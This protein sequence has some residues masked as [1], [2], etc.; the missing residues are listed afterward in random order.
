VQK[1]F[2]LQ[3]VTIYMSSIY[4][5]TRIVSPTLSSSLFYNCICTNRVPIQY[6]THL[7]S[8]FRRTSHATHYTNWH[9]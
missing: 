5:R 2:N 3:Q 7:A 8:H 6:Q 1:D 9:W 4:T